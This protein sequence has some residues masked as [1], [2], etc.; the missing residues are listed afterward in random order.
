M[1]DDGRRWSWNTF[2]KM[3][4]HGCRAILLDPLY[5]DDDPFID[6]LPVSKLLLRG[7]LEDQ[8]LWA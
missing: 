2:Y 1:I 5:P 6:K 8:K 3:T 4:Y 7:N